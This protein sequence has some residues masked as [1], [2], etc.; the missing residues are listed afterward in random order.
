MTLIE[1]EKWTERIVEAAI[2][3]HPNES[4]VHILTEFAEKCERE[5]VDEYCD[6]T[7]YADDRDEAIR[8][9]VEDM[10]DGFRSDPFAEGS[11]TCCSCGTEF[12]QCPVCLINREG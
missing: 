5:A 11:L 4:I 2:G 8:E 12:N 7:E 9:A 6:S 3:D 1:Q 10:E